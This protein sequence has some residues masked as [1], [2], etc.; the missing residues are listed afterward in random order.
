MELL[1][2]NLTA[3]ETVLK[4]MDTLQST[5]D[6]F[7]RQGV[8]L[9]AF[10]NYEIANDIVFVMENLNYQKFSVFGASFGTLVVQHLLLN[11]SE[12]IESAVMNAVVDVNHCFSNMHTNSIKTLD[13]IFERCEK[14]EEIRQ[15]FPE[16]KNRFLALIEKL[17]ESPDTILVRRPG[18]NKMHNMVLNGNRLSV[19]IFAQMYWNT[20]IPL[21][22]SKLFA[23]DYSEIIQSPHILFPLQNFS[24]GLY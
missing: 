1:S 20:Q 16:L 4:Y 22:L 21:T 6:R 7:N 5:Y 13:V 18:T 9:S 8:N 23:G 12:H 11:H 15:A 3:E 10:N 14:D 24:N 2:K 19:W 17:N